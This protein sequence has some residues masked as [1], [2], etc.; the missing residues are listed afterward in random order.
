MRLT[1]R[2]LLAWL[3]DTLSPA[4]VREIGNQVAESPFAQELKGRIQLVTRQRRLTIPP[5][6]GPNATDPNL[7]A[8]YLDNEL[9][10]EHVADFEKL[11]L[12]SDVNLAEVRHQFEGGDVGEFALAG[13]F[14]AGLDLGIAGEAERILADGGVEA[15]AQQ[16]VEDFRA[17]L[18]AEALLDDLR[19]HLAGAEALDAGGARHFAQAA[20]DLGIDPFRRQAEGHA[21][22]EVAERFDRNLH[23]WELFVMG[24]GQAGEQP[25]GTG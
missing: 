21:A 23:C 11:C 9:A 13:R 12:T 15:L 4:E 8:A 6:D 22:F 10:P 20:T 2:T 14:G 18:V 7:V 1:L 3:D 17:D 16:A 5:T 24:G 25:G 19:G